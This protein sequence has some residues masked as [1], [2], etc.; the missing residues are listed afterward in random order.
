MRRKNEGSN[1][2][3]LEAG[4]V[5]NLVAHQ[6]LGALEPAAV[7]LSLRAIE[8]IHRDRQRLHRHWKQRLERSAYEAERAE[9]QYQSVE[10]ENRL[11]ACSMERQWEH[12]LQ[13][14]RDLMEEYERF[15]REL[16]PHLSEDQR[17][18]ILALSSDLPALW[19]ASETTAAD[20]KEIIRLV[21]DRVVVH[22]RTDSECG[23]A[24]I[25]WRDGSTTRHEIVRP[26]SRYESLGRYNQLLSRIV[27]LRQQGRTIKQ[28]VARLNEEGYHT[29]RSRKGYTATSV[30]KLLSR[31]ELTRERAGTRLLERHE[32]WLPE[33]A[34]AVQIPVDTLRH[35][36]ARG[37]I[38]ARQ[39]PP[40]GLW[41]VW[42]DAPER[43][44]LS[45]LVIDSKRDKPGK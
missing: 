14:Q 40:R 26:V 15:S 36:A 9:R 24:V 16:P 11:V 31:C 28:I 35:W 7:K 32:W 10:P 4:T 38:R 13:T 22:A 8:D 19:N 34:R 23:E 43:R 41:I 25:W 27:D 5:D 21:V 30:R 29:P 1:C 45:K 44:R 12:A 3:G 42:A 18:Q 37:S 17:A 33:L 39:V 20:R 2:C 6:V